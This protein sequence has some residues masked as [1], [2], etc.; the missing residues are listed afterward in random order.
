LL[1]KTGTLT[2][3]APAVDG[4]H[5]R[6]PI[7]ADRLLQAAASLDQASSHIVANA[8]VGETRRRAMSLTYPADVEESPGQGVRGRVNG[9]KV[10]LGSRTYLKAQGVEV[11]AGAPAPGRADVQV[12][13]D[14]RYAG[15]I[16][17][18]DRLRSDAT[19]LVPGLRR[20]GVRR[21]VLATGDQGPVAY[22]IA[23]QAGIEEVYSELSAEQKML[24]LGKL[25]ACPGAGAVVMV[26]DG[27][28]D[29]PA[30]AAAD[31]G[32]A[33]AAGSATAASQTADAVVVVDRVMRVVDAITIGRRAMHIARQSV[34]VGLG[35]SGIGMALAAAGLLPPI[36]G[37]LA[38]EA[39]DVGVI[40][41]ALRALRA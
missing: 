1:D 15:T 14:D 29:A 36:A 4:V 11:P 27:V 5:P 37:A 26:G 3:G 7:D 21:V 35:V 33:M 8:L 6:P 10:A 41:N 34:L 19:D 2:L 32:I 38:Q 28:N 17:I 31:V 12:A 20:A 13:I 30:L 9:R 25:R 39:I 18:T 23:D 22:A 24:L 16:T 40:L